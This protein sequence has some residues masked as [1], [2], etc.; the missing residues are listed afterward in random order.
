MMK[1]KWKHALAALLAAVLML[2]VMGC[3][4]NDDEPTTT[5]SSDA[6]ADVDTAADRD[7]IAVKIGDDYT[8]TKGEIQ[9]QYDYMIE[10]YSYYGMGTPTEDADIESMQDSIISSLV[11]DKI[12][13]YE[14][15]LLDILLTDEEVADVEAQAE[16]EMQYYLDSFRAE[17]ENEGAEDVEARTLEI[18]QEQLDAAEMDMDVEGFRAYIV[19]GYMNEAWKVAL[20]EEITRDITATDEEIQNYYA[21]N[22]AT[23][24]EDY[25]TTPSYYLSDSEAYQMDGS[26]PILYAPEG[27]VRVRSISISPAEEISSDYA[28]LL[29]DLDTLSA[30]YGKAALAA[31]ADKYAETSADPASKQLPITA[32]EIEGGE[33]LVTEYVQKKAEADAM[34]EEYVQDARAKAN[35][36][37]AALE[38]GTDFKDVLTQYGENDTYISYPSF[39][40][41]G[42]LML[43]A[44]DDVWD[45]QLV[46]AVGLLKDGQH[47]DV[48]QIGDT[49]YILQLVGKEPAGETPLSDVYD[50]I[51]AVV[52]QNN[53]DDYWNEMLQSWENDTSI[54]TYYEDVYR[55]IG[56]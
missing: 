55:D 28:T 50:A 18:F 3:S 42:L 47:T 31:L 16:E 13:L 17:A 45:S 40:E 20:K 52:V 34:Y 37:Y 48:I 33:A 14:A 51:Q 19:E 2:S 53:V 5:T 38:S 29:S 30:Q 49:F 26:N 54:A 39:V 9:D 56:K 22:L 21:E 35:E 8:I 36:A 25:T 10:M 11:S 23:Q 41:T 32:S 6:S 27:Y 1:F 4:L 43:A 15:K 12:Q 46:D 44:G 7:Q 24:Q